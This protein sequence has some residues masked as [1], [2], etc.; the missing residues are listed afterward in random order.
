MDAGASLENGGRRGRTWRCLEAASPGGKG[1]GK[2]TANLLLD[3]E[4]HVLKLGE[5]FAKRPKSLYHTI[6]YDVK[7][8]A[9]GTSG[10]GE[11]QL[12][13]GDEVT[14]TLPR[15]AGST[16]ATTVFKGNKRPYET[17]CVL[18]INHDTGEYV[19]EKLCSRIQVKKMRTEGSGGI[20]ARKQQQL[21]AG[22]PFRAPVKA[23]VEPKAPP[24]QGDLS[25]ELQLDDFKRLL[26]AETEVLEERSSGSGS[27]SS[28]SDSSR[29]SEGD[30]PA[31]RAAPS[32]P[33]H[34]HLSPRNPVAKGPGRPRGNQELMDILRNDLRLSDSGSDSDDERTSFLPPSLC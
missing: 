29:D 10:D 2:H 11:L 12:G 28:D 25:A 9:T 18:I 23:P 24:V 31:A 14:I 8:E 4:P 22:A 34:Q 32:Q 26:R 1:A 7:P 30:E 19:L 3:R 6:R 33:P 16:P 17:D 20:Q 27:S 5:S 15:V 21:P 13:K